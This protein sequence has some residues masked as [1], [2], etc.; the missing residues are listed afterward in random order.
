MIVSGPAAEPAMRLFTPSN[1][2]SSEASQP[3]GTPTCRWTPPDPVWMRLRLGFASRP[4]SARSA[5]WFVPNDRLPRAT[6]LASCLSSCLRLRMRA[7]PFSAPPAL[8]SYCR[9]NPARRGSR[10][11]RVDVLNPRRTA[12][13]ASSGCEAG[14]LRRLCFSSVAV[15]NNPPHWLTVATAGLFRRTVFASA[16]RNPPA[17]RD[18]TRG[19][20]S[21]SPYHLSVVSRVGTAHRQTPCSHH[22]RTAK[23]TVGA[24][25]I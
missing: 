8:G 17:A 10:R 24:G 15:G 1:G 22:R 21:A 9:T 16:G 13:L 19:L 6:G 2:L 20:V 5:S 11:T 7:T 14:D 18:S 12:P 3:A 25:E 23:S 4:L